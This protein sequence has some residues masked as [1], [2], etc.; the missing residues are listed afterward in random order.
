MV[1]FTDLPLHLSEEHCDDFGKFGI[2]FNKDKF[3]N[4]V[5]TQFIIL[6]KSA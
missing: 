3:I 4:M 1:C 5:Q 2:G 6:L